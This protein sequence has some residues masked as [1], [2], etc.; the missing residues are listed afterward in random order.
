MQGRIRK[1]T[2][3]GF[4]A[5]MAFWLGIFLCYSFVK[6]RGDKDFLILKVLLFCEPVIYFLAL[7]GYLKKRRTIYILTLLFLAANA[8]LSVTDEVGFFDIISLLLN[9]GLLLLL[10]AQRGD[11]TGKGK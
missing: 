3:S 9:A 2:I 5:N 4:I 1:I 6:Y 11:F 7:W 10:A 8:A